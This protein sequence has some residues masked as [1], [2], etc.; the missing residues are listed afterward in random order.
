MIKQNNMTLIQEL[1]KRIDAGVRWLNKKKPS[2]LKK[3]DLGMLDMKATPVCICGQLFRNFWN[4]VLEEDEM[5]KK[6]EK[7][8]TYKESVARGFGGTNSEL[9]ILTRLWKAKIMLLRK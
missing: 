3:I 1:Q 2:W 7:K 4:V 6:G 8:M 5:K 9:D